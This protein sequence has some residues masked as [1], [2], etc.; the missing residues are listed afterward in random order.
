M[1][2][3][4]S[5]TIK[6]Q[7]RFNGI[8]ENHE[9]FHRQINLTSGC[10]D[11]NVFNSSNISYDIKTSNVAPA[12]NGNSSND[13]RTIA[14]ISN[15]SIIH[16]LESELSD[17]L[18]APYVV[19]TS[20]GE[21]AICLALMLAAQ[22][23]YGSQS[24][25]GKRVFCSDL[26]PI[27]EATSILSENGIPTFIDVT[28]YDFNMNP[29]CLEIAFDTYPDTRIV[30]LDHYYGFP[31]N[32][33]EIK[34]IC[35]SHGALLI[36]N[37]SDSF[38]AKL[39][40]RFT[41][42]FGDIAILDFGKD[43]II[44]GGYGGA[45]ILQNEGDFDMIRAWMDSSFADFP[46]GD[47]SIKDSSTKGTSFISMSHT[48]AAIVLEQLPYIN[49]IISRKKEIYDMYQDNLNPDLISMIDYSEDAEPNF[50]MSV[51]MCD[52][53]VSAAELES[54]YDIISADKYIYTDYHGI[55]S[56]KEISE[57]LKAF[58]A[59]A[60]PIPEAMSL[61]PAFRD[62]ELVTLDGEVRCSQLADE[63]NSLLFE[64]MSHDVS[65]KCICLPTD[66]SMTEEEQ[67][68]VIEL[69]HSCFSRTDIDRKEFATV[70]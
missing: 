63:E 20:S 17:Y 5:Q 67:G 57:V 60:V 65:K 18:G 28:D 45:I 1:D 2:E 6:Y 13:D 27:E 22:K 10:N 52:S 3:Q 53:V 7:P 36:E 4:I 49:E 8:F 44:N 26:C 54:R 23:F 15:S 42:T 21:I 46:A 31:G 58:G 38:G 64:A 56:P 69:I 55:S 40:G 62:F 11:L 14:G 70:V 59:E 12:S 33:S 25:S 30:I 39:D 48:A 43:K 16:K 9:G 35:Q 34:E 68:K 32:A 50:E 41:G 51:A 24:L 66:L 47:S 37:A 19:A 29:E 61:R